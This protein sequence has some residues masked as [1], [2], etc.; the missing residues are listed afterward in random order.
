MRQPYQN[1]QLASAVYLKNYKK[2]L[3]AASICCWQGFFNKLQA[4]PVL[5]MHYVVQY[6]I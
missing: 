5:Y 4:H 1:G 6:D 3:F 2:S